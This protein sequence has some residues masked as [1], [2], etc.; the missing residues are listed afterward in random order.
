MT[1]ICFFDADSV[2]LFADAERFKAAMTGGSLFLRRTERCFGRD[3][4]G[5]IDQIVSNNTEVT[6]ALCLTKTFIVEM[7]NVLAHL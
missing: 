6:S 7:L 4:P 2:E 1:S 3:L 5:M